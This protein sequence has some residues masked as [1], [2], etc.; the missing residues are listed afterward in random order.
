MKEIIDFKQRSTWGTFPK[1]MMLAMLVIFGFALDLSAD[2]TAQKNYGLK[3]LTEEHI[4]HIEQ[5]LHWVHHVQPNKLG[6]ARI[7]KHLKAH[8]KPAADFNIAYTHHEEY[9]THQ[10]KDHPEFEAVKDAPPLPSHVNNSTLPSFPPIGDQRDLGACVAW[11]STY[12]QATHE[13][14]LLNGT[15]NKN[16]Y[17]NVLS[18]KWT[19]NLLNN[20]I[21]GGLNPT[22]AFQLLSQ[23]GAA[24]IVNFPYD[25]NYR[26]WDLNPQDWVS[27]ISYRTTSAQMISGIGGHQPQNLQVIKQALNNGHVL[28]FATFVES[29][30]YTTVGTNPSNSSNPYAGQQA[31]SW[32]NGSNGGH[33]MTIVGYDDNV[34]ID[35]NGNGKVDPGES[36]AF[37]IANSWSASWGNNGFIWVAYDAFNGVSVVPHGPN[38]GR[39]PLAD[40]MNSYVVSILPKAANYT[41]KLIAEF[42]LS[43][44]IR[45]QILVQGGISDT[46]HTTPAVTYLCDALNYQ[47]G[48]FEFNGTTPG[49]PETATFTVDLTDLL[50]SQSSVGTQR[51]YLM[52]TDNRSG[53]PT[54]LTSFSLIDNVH[55]N[56]VH[57]SGTLPAVFDHN[58][59]TPF[60]DYD[61]NSSSLPANPNDPTV[62]ITSPSHGDNLNGSVDVTINATSTLGISKVEFYVDSVLQTTDTTSPYLA[63]VDTTKLSDGSHQFSVIAYDTENNTSQS[64]ITISV[65]NAS[66]PSAIYVN[67]GGDAVT[68]QGIQWQSDQGFTTSSN[69]YSTNLKFANQVYQ[70]ERHGNF[71]YN[72]AVANGSHTVTLKFAEIYFKKIGKRVFNVF[73]NGTQVIDKLD[74]VKTAG[75]KVPLD[76]SFP[77]NVTDNN[78]KIDFQSVTNNAKVSAIQIT[79]P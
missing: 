50:P 46:S 52:I 35:I 42:S 8:G 62:S 28:T 21:D 38:H 41:P 66:Y 30:V 6:A 61:F 77:V 15:N 39:V 11:G 2:S 17:N 3:P 16:S 36:G 70:T 26:A 58:T 63:S 44:S 23:N 9:L 71:S 79:T 69:T 64:S 65:Q 43:Q 14:G 10:G 12:Y 49:T 73:I 72:F 7:Q 31:V 57:Y 47:G 56:Q 5:N 34:W 60:I 67:A 32:M 25:E 45:D 75:F 59:I 54:N 24:T 74:L 53:N 37:L 13:V 55:N 18:P 76:L 78:I 68:S 19:Y 48:P 22:D 33:Y 40:A 29:W 1:R 4:Q 27:A 51:Y 20:G